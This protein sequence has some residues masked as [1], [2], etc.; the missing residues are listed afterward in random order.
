MCRSRDFHH[1]LVLGILREKKI[2]SPISSSP[3]PAF[4]GDIL[5]LRLLVN[6]ELAEYKIVYFAKFRILP[7]ISPFHGIPDSH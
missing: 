4:S 2:S 5:P 1:V 6:I 7:N 3:W